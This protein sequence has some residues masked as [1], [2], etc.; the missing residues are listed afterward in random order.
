MMPGFLAEYA[1]GKNYDIFREG[2]GKLLM[3]GAKIRWEYHTHAVDKDI[4]GHPV[5]ALYF[6]PKGA[7][8][9]V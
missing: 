6:Y 4:T 1:I 2:T 5:L 3:P 8:T 7:D 9:Q